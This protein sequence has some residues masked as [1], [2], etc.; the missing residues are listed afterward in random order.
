MQ[1][2]EH[3]LVRTATNPFKSLKNTGVWGEI[4]NPDVCAYSSK[5]STYTQ[6]N[7]TDRKGNAKAKPQ[8]A[9]SSQGS[10]DQ[11]VWARWTHVFYSK[12]VVDTDFFCFRFSVS[13]F[14]TY[15]Y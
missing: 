9:I 6:E 4:N 8:P 13:L 5:W 15:S 7:H 10:P 14:H 12:A 1:K 11:F 2:Q 3:E